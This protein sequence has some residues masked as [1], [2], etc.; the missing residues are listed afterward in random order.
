EAHFNDCCPSSGVMALEELPSMIF[1]QMDKGIAVNLFVESEATLKTGTSNAV[2]ISQKT[3]YPFDGK[4]QVFVSPAKSESFPIFVRIPDWVTTAKVTLNGKPWDAQALVKGAFFRIE[5]TWQAKDVVEFEFPME[6]RVFQKT[7]E[8]PIPQGGGEIFR[9]N[10]LAMAKGPLV[11]SAN[12]LIDGKDRER[13]F[14]LS[15]MVASEMF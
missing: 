10:W 1:S 4:I 6:I 15:S 9:V 3:Q 7:E 11:Y 5:R 2:R 8:A 12:G 14:Q 13:T